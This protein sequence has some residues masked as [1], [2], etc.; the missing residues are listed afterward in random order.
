LWHLSDR[1]ASPRTLFNPSRAWLRTW[2]RWAGED[3]LPQMAGRGYAGQTRDHIRIDELELIV[4]ELRRQLG[5]CR[6]KE[7]ALRREC[8]DKVAEANASLEESRHSWE[9]E[10]RQLTELLQATLERQRDFNTQLQD[11]Q[12]I[13]DDLDAN[14]AQLEAENTHLRNQLQALQQVNKIEEGSSEQLDRHMRELIADLKDERRWRVEAQ[15]RAEKLEKERAAMADLEFGSSKTEQLLEEELQAV[16]CELIASREEAAS[17][18]G[19]LRASER[20]EL[21]SEAGFESGLAALEESQAPDHATIHQLDHHISDD[22][23][24]ENQRL[25]QRI[26]QLES[27]TS[28]RIPLP[29][30]QVQNGRA[31]S[32][33]PVG[34][35]NPEQMRRYIDNAPDSLLSRVEAAWDTAATPLRHRHLDHLRAHES[36]D[37]RNQHVVR[38]QEVNSQA[39]APVARKAVAMEAETRI[40]LA[41]S[42]AMARRMLGDE[43][44][45]MEYEGIARRLKKQQRGNQDDKGRSRP[46]ASGPRVGA[47]PPRTRSPPRSRASA[48]SSRVG[49]TLPH[50]TSEWASVIQDRAYPVR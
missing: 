19:Q 13:W 21:L 18:R 46:L 16:R 23:A 31:V 30:K 1:R 47:S 39:V 32:P 38:A 41:Q 25:Q 4:E 34:T 9:A 28:L 45:A 14:R 10:R 26:S 35:S 29:E 44:G 12:L 8:D 27:R 36:R 3:K 48:S 24:K 22:L 42:K 50:K 7:A 33:P 2:E 20:A 43:K 11:Q 40:A 17:L 37:G 6:T 49:S 15:R 5:D